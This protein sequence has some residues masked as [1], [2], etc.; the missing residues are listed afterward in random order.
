MT[1][2]QLLPDDV[3]GK[4]AAGEVIERPASVVKE[5]VE[6]SL[7]AGATEVRIEIRAGGRELIRV[8]DDG[9]GISPDE[10]PLA[11]SPH[12]TSKLRSENDLQIGMEI[13]IP[14]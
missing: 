14:N 3:R 7:D 2:I 13:L 4:I 8:L 10:L 1:S 9:A 5:L 6:N 11:F 12:A